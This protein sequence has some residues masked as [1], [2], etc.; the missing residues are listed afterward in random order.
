MHDQQIDKSEIVVEQEK[1]NIQQDQT[2]KNTDCL[3]Q[4]RACLILTGLP[5]EKLT[6]VRCQANHTV[7]QFAN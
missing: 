1:A 7:G 3:D 6:E 4:E 2:V 5:M